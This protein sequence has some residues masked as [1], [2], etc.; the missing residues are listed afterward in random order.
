MNYRIQ[1]GLVME[2]I[3]GTSLLIATLKAR[4]HCPYVMQLNEAAAYVWEM[5]FQGK[6]LDEM[7]ARIADDFEMSEEE[8]NDALKSFLL[9]LE[10]DN[11]LIIEEEDKSD[12]T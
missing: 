1:E 4:K 12:E 6:M 10:K 3:C 11:Y 9:E 2:T 7:A 5:L 8:A